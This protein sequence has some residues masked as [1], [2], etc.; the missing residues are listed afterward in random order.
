[1]EKIQLKTRA[2]LAIM[3]RGGVI[4]RRVLDHVV[5]AAK[6]GVTTG[7][8]DKLAR[9]LMA[10]AGAKPACLGYRGYPA[11]LCTS[12]NSEVVHGIPGPR[13]LV[14]GDI[15]SIDCAL[16]FEGFVAD[17]AATAAVGSVSPEAERLLRVTEESLRRGIEQMVV[18]KRC[19]DVS[20]AVQRHVE[21]HGY[22][23]VRDY[24]GHGVGRKMH[25]PPQLPNFGNPGTG[26]R[27]LPGTVIA[28]E[29]MVNAGAWRTKTLKDGWT[30]VTSDG[31]LSAHF[32][33]TV[34][35]T[36]DEPL[37]LTAPE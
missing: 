22:S 29:P 15:V 23:V 25:E 30:V 27:L 8:L 31:S 13:V 12:V 21:D 33:H 1:M 28:I 10:E 34:A 18:G 32:E 16:I 37:V 4:A 3:R 17:N 2:E 26:Q 36:E 6:P 11:T 14:E 9:R 7:E 20:A 19:G 24:T 35:V 5:A